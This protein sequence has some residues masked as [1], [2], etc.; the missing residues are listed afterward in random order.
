MLYKFCEVTNQSYWLIFKHL[1]KPTFSCSRK[2]CFSCGLFFWFGFTLQAINKACSEEHSD[3][4]YKRKTKQNK[5]NPCKSTWPP[6]LFNTF[7]ENKEPHLKCQWRQK[8]TGSTQNKESNPNTL[9]RPHNTGIL[10]KVV[11][12]L[13]SNSP[14][15]KNNFI[16]FCRK[17]ILKR[18]IT[19]KNRK[20][21]SKLW[22]SKLSAHTARTLQIC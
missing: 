19:R 8:G 10:E 13:I 14:G 21:G 18:I 22:F 16:H 11:D 20:S 5:K 6:I 2:E 12:I 15:V 1:C 17:E 3:L 4:E 7:H 9:S